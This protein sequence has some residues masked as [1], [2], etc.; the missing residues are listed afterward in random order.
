MPG[1]S[2]AVIYEEKGEV[3]SPLVKT[4]TQAHDIL[5]ESSHMLGGYSHREHSKTNIFKQSK[6][7]TS[8]NKSQLMASSLQ[9]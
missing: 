6:E 7:R 3:M 4:V 9:R 1:R 8:I 5:H 2:V